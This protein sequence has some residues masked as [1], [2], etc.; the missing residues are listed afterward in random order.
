MWRS[1]LGFTL[2]EVLLVVAIITL[3]A[4]ITIPVGAAYLSRSDLSN[5]TSSVVQSLRQA[6]S[7]AFY[8]NQDDNWGVRVESGTITIYKG[9]D[10]ATRD[11][12]FDT[13]I[14]FRSSVVVS[15][16]Q[17]V[18]FTRGSG[19]TASPITINLSDGSSSSEINVSRIGVVSQ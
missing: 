3:S 2:I 14:P 17:E 13:T 15:G 16:D 8:S 4:A 5:T 12:S 6:Q 7:Y 11:S 18:L 1:R 19:R 9:A 10:Y